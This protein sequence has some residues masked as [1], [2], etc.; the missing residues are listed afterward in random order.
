MGI[1][2]VHVLL[3][4]PDAEA[5]RAFFRALGW[6]HVE[7]HDPPDGWQ[8]FALPPAELGIHP[9][10]GSTKHAMTLM[11]DELESTARELQRHGAEVRGEPL[12]EDF[13]LALDLV[14]PG[15]VPVLLYE[16]RHPTAI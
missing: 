16:P 10:D 11:C 4:T 3:Y 2:G 7:A 5:L 6:D 1:T 8:I 13:G 14:L 9:S 12:D 15:G